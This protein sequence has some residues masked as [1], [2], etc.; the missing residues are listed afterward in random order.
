MEESTVDPLVIENLH[1]G[2]R[3]EFVRRPWNGAEELRFRGTLPPGRAGPPL[4]AHLRQEEGVRVLRGRLTTM[5]SGERRE[6]GPGEELVI[7]PGHPHRWWN[8][9]DETLEFEAWAR[10]AG[11]LDRYLQGLFEVQN[12]GPPGRPPLTYLAHLMM[13][14]RGS[15]ALRLISGVVQSATFSLALVAGRLMG[16]Y[17]GSEWPGAPAR[18]TGAPR[19]DRD[20]RTTAGT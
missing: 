2:E 13:R 6:V 20:D 9:G 15:Q 11:D 5:V 8:A 3:L 17:R 1:T 7:P 14:H 19:A 18:C 12:A 4:H 16:R 10:P